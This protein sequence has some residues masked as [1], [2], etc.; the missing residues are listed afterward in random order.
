M[1]DLISRQTAIDAFY[2]R[3]NIDWTTIDVVK[4]LNALPSA[5]PHWIPCSERN[6]DRDGKYLV[7]SARHKL[8]RVKTFTLKY[9][10]EEGM[11]L[12]WMPL[13]KPYGGESD[14]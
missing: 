4:K 6:P 7:T 11:P 1:S 14:G 8:V 2:S 13:P 5:Q 12:A 9:W 10:W 3:P